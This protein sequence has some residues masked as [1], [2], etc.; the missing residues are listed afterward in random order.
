MSSLAAAYAVK[1]HGRKSHSPDCPGCGMCKG[2]EM[3]AEGGDVRSGKNR[4]D[5]EQGVHKS[6]PGGL[7][8]SS[9]GGLA[10]VGK[11]LHDKGDRA[12][13]YG[14]SHAGE[15]ATNMSKDLHRAKLDEMR[16]MKKPELYAEGGE[17]ED[18]GLVARIMRKMSEGGIISNDS[19]PMADGESADFDDLVEDDHL[20]GHYPGSEELGNAKEE[21][22]EDEDRSMVSRIMR[23]RS[24]KRDGL[25][26]I[27]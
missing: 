27:A 13:V 3:M 21:E 18:D 23:K 22:M 15:N 16:S 5:Y 1:K 4:R 26:R 2:G 14:E 11:K 19:D 10:K 12:R 9:A 25:S 8:E 7:G 17:V 6:G 24:K 20:E